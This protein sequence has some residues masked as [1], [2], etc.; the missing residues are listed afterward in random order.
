ML[1]CLQT[2]VEKSKQSLNPS[3]KQQRK[4][5]LSEEAAKVKA[6]YVHDDYDMVPVSSPGGQ[7]SPRA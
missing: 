7:R 4:L 3:G 1:L 6:Q 5:D 2:V